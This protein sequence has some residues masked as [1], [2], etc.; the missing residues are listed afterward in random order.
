[1]DRII[2]GSNW[3]C[4]EINQRLRVDETTLPALSREMSS[5]VLGGGYFALDL[6]GEIQALTA[7]M[8]VNGAHEDLRTR[9]GREPG[10][11]T[12]VTYYESLLDVFPAGSDGSVQTNGAPKLNGRVVFLKGLLNEYTPPGVKGL[13]ASGA[14]RLRFSSIVLYHDIFNGKTI[15]KFDVQNNTLI[16]DGINYTAEHNRLISA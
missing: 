2:H 6:P 10:D 15:H 3:Y 9:F 11:W 14:T 8:T 16:I 7:E 12:T 1:M 5:V 13:K 4:G